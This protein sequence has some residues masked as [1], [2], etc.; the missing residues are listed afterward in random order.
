MTIKN[1]TITQALTIHNI[2]S[3]C[4]IVLDLLDLTFA[5]LFVILWK[6][7]TLRNWTLSELSQLPR[8][9]QLLD[10]NSDKSDILFKTKG[11]N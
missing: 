7:R 8:T 5:E 9:L 6:E 11:E 1:T 2:N 3:W 10:G 4:Q